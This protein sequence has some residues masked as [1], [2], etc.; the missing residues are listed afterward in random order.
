MWPIARKQLCMR[1][2]LV[3]SNDAASTQE[4]SLTCWL[5]AHRV[6]IS[7]VRDQVLGP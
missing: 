1:G 4:T 2:V 5:A 6:V 7:L 3:S